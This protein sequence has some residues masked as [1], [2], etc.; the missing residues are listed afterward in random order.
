MDAR[1][2]ERS[3]LI[4]SLKVEN[5]D[6]GDLIGYIVDINPD[7]MMLI[8]ESELDVPATMEMKIHLPRIVMN[9]ATVI[10]S[11]EIRWCRK[12]V[13]GAYYLGVRLAEIPENGREQVDELMDRFRQLGADDADAND[14]YMHDLDPSDIVE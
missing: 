10:V 3:Q 11:G 7:G 5:T 1:T 4:Y 8:S 12:R 14:P 6:T 13:S 2:T 9:E